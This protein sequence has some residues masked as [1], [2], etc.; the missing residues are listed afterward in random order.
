MMSVDETLMCSFQVLKPT[1]KRPKGFSQ[2]LNKAKAV[3][4]SGKKI[5]GM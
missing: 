5:N 3:L 1:E 2:N 4:P